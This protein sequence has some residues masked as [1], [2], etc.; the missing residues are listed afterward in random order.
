VVWWKPELRTQCIVIVRLA[1]FGHA[2]AVILV[3]GYWFFTLRYRFDFTPFMTLAAIIGYRSIS[4]AVSEGRASW[5][6]RAH[7]AAIGLCL[8]GILSSHYVLLMHKLWCS[9]IPIDVRHS[10]VPFAP[11]IRPE[12]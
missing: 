1:L 10:L 7:V 12:C 8:L 5:R 11:F 2:S 4:I 9:K 3:L 6:R